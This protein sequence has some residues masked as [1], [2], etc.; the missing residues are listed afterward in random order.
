VAFRD[1]RHG[2]AVGLD[3]VALWTD[4]AGKSWRQVQSGTTNHLFDVAW[5]TDRWVAIGDMGLVATSPP[6]RPAWRTRRL[7]EHELA[8]H[9]AMA[10]CTGTLFLVGG[11]QGVL[12]NKLWKPWESP[13]EKGV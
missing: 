3:G 5:E 12:L 1:P 13:I 4:D 6:G 11:S 10:A 8:W 2:V 7:A 9:T